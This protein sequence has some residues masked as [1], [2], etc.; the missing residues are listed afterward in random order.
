MNK[1][2]I[3]S[4]IGIPC[5]GKSTWINKYANDND[6]VVVNPDSIRGRLSGGNEGDQSRNDEVFKIA[7]KELMNELIKGNSVCYDACCYNSSNRKMVED[8]AQKTGANI[9]W[10]V[11]QV[12]LDTA[13]KRQET[14]ER[15]VPLHV[16]E[17]MINGMSIPVP[18]AN[19]KIVRH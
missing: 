1:L 16:M 19:V 11:F 6:L 5:S 12:S 2:T 15:K 10:H 18:N 7:A 3:Y 17:K 8:I 13:V 4:T 9:T 14:R